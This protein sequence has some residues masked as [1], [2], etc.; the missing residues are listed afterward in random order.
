MTTNVSTQNE[1]DFLLRTGM[2]NRNVFA[3]IQADDCVV[4]QQ[5]VGGFRNYS[6]C[7]HTCVTEI[8]GKPTGGKYTCQSS[9]VFANG[10]KGFAPREAIVGWTKKVAAAHAVAR[11]MFFANH[12]DAYCEEFRIPP[13]W[14]TA[15][16]DELTDPKKKVEVNRFGGSPE[17]H[18][19]CAD[20]ISDCKAEDLVVNL[21]TPGRR[22]ITDPQ[23]VKDFAANPPQILAVSFDDVDLD[24]IERLAAMS[25]D[26][27]KAEWKKISPYHGQRQKAYEGLY[28][29]KLINEMGLSVKILFNVVTHTGNID[30][31]HN[32]LETL[33][34]CVP[35][36]L[37]NA[38]PAQSFA[39]EPLCWTEESLTA[40]RQHILQLISDTL[41]GNPLI[42]PR[43]SYYN[44]LEAAFRLWWPN[45]KHRLCQFMSGVG[46]WDFTL[47]PGA[48]R[49]AQIAS[50]TEIVAL[51]RDQLTSPGGHLG[52]F[53][54][55][56]LSFSE[57]IDGNIEELAHA[58][59]VGMVARGK[60]LRA[61]NKLE[62][63]QTSNIMPRLA[64]D[65][66]SL[67][68][69]IP[70]ELV[71]TYLETRLEFCRF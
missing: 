27:I 26:E 4:W 68:L 7:N 67:E 22:L 57:Q 38:F 64:L 33:K 71:E 23:F 60:E 44:M 24:E 65:T 37:V 1:R 48:Y 18:P 16:K 13:A 59:T 25:L 47:R 66:L 49:Y 2:I 63:V 45:D 40:L 51:D 34:Q 39:G 61:A 46:A 70:I 43:I 69:G 50:S 56:H 19:Q 62:Y 17:M 53:W 6:L 15:I 8:K 29:A 30:H 21:T 31:L 58:M 41:D 14:A 5:V 35:G 11:D 54:N 3:G 52:C 42:N 9:F 12:Y 32:I 10:A 28:A 20:I 55:P 36:C